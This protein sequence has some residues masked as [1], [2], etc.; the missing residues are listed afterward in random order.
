MRLVAVVA[1]IVMVF[2][3]ASVTQAEAVSPERDTIT[4]K[5]GEKSMEIGV[6]YTA[7]TVRAYSTPGISK[8]AKPRYFQV[9]NRL[10]ADEHTGLLGERG[11][12]V[13]NSLLNV[14]G[15]QSVVIR[16]DRIEVGIG[17]ACSWRSIQPVVLS[18]FRA[19]LLEG[20]SYM[21]GGTRTRE[22]FRIIDTRCI[23]RTTERFFFNRRLEMKTGLLVVDPTLSV[24]RLEREM[25]VLDQPAK[26]LVRELVGI[27]GARW[28]WLQP[29]SASISLLDEADWDEARPLVLEAI[30]RACG[31][32]DLDCEVIE[33]E[34][35]ARPLLLPFPSG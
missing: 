13:V 26:H 31:E 32:R 7:E 12:R 35:G 29:Y 16:P 9:P 18:V 11:Y 30:C 10:R 15:V 34:R 3:V 8:E 23:N 27:D 28:I 19:I 20:L 33:L 21:S 1:V 17:R 4:L 14:E 25:R 6:E 24:P 5:Y 2:I 22:P